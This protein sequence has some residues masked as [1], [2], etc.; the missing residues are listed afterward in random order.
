M[1][2]ND[3]YIYKAPDA[4]DKSAHY[5][6]AVKDL[7]HISG[8]PTSAGN[9][10][11]LNSHPLPT[12]TSSVVTT[13]L[14]AGVK[15]IGKTITDELAY[16]LNGINIHYGTCINY[17]HPDRIVGGSSSGSALAVAQG[18]AN[19]G[20]G[21]DTGGSIRVPAS[22][23][24]LF[25]IRPTHGRVATDGMVSLAPSFDTVGWMSKDLNT[26]EWVA[27]LLITSDLCPQQLALSEVA[28]ADDLFNQV[29]HKQQS[30]SWLNDI[31]P[32]NYQLNKTLSIETT[33]EAA[34][35][36]RI[37]QGAEIWKTHGEWFERQQPA[38]ASDI[39]QR[40]EW[41][42]RITTKEIEQALRFQKAFKNSIDDILERHP[43]IVLPTTPGP[44]PMLSG[45]P[46]TMAKY[47]NQLLAFT[48]TAGLCGLPQ[49]H[50]PV[51]ECDKSAVGVSIMTRRD[52]DLSLVNL[53]KIIMEKKT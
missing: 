44:A 13:L 48:A 46:E 53:A 35:A 31:F 8:I 37:L 27:K 26:L 7:F 12:E 47:R 2:V 19:I 40:F 4:K 33:I 20:L 21:T 32:S 30:E 25:G 5:S 43:V 38:M 50:L 51:L 52:A 34:S 24:G 16:S 42:S 10:D 9:I 49:L 14:Q 1:L 15:L 36:F 23:N 45:D 3:P 41:C 29:E 28:I 6:L 18:S 17:N 39:K 11:W 22:Y